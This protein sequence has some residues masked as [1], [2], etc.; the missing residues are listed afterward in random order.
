M[1]RTHK[2]TC[3]NFGTQL[4]VFKITENGMGQLNVNSSNLASGVYSYSLSV[5]WK[6]VDTK[7]M[8]CARK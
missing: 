1:I 7:K 8:E 5:K 3:T 2:E 4:K 6:I